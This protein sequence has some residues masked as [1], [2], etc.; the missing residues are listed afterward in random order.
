[1]R[2]ARQTLSKP[3]TPLFGR[4]REI[5]ELAG[6]LD[7]ERLVTLLGPGGCGKTR[8]AIETALRLAEGFHD[9]IGFVDL[10]RVG[11][12]VGPDVIGRLVGSALAFS[13]EAAHDPAAYLGERRLLLV[14]DNCEHV[15]ESAAAC[16][17][18]LLDL[19]PN[20]R[21]LATSREALAV[22]GE[23]T[24]PLVPLACPPEG[25]DAD[26][27]A[28]DAT[29]M[30]LERARRVQ[31]TFTPS[32][33]ELVA[34]AAIARRL[35]GI[36][37]ALELAAARVR[38]LGPQEILQGLDANLDLVAADVR[39]AAPRQH[40]LRASMQWSYDLLSLPE[41][42]VLRRLAVFPG[43]FD[44]AAADAVAGD[45]SAAVAVTDRLLQLVDKSL[46]TRTD[47]GLRLL[48]TV[49]HY[50]LERLRDSGEE[51]QTRER[52]RDL[53]LRRAQQAADRLWTD[54]GI[55]AYQ[56]LSATQDDALQALR[57]CAARGDLDAVA[58]IVAAYAEPLTMLWVG[59]PVD[60][61]ELAVPH[62]AHVPAPARADLLFAYACFV[63]KTQS[64]P[65][66]GLA[67]LAA[68]TVD[69]HLPARQRRRCVIAACALSAYPGREASARAAEVRQEALDAGH[70]YD[71]VVAQVVVWR[72]AMAAARP[73]ADEQAELVG[74]LASRGGPLLMSTVL[75]NYTCY[76]SAPRLQIRAAESVLQMGVDAIPSV[77]R[78]L[79]RDAAF[80]EKTLGNFSVAAQHAS[81]VID[82]F[83][84]NGDRV[85]A[86]FMFDVLALGAEADG[87]LDVALELSDRARE[88]LEPSLLWMTFSPLLLARAAALHVARHEIHRA[89]LLVEEMVAVPPERAGP[90]HQPLAAVA[91]ALI[92][93]AADDADAVRTA[94]EALVTAARAG[95]FTVGTAL[96]VAAA[97]DVISAEDTAALERSARR[98]GAASAVI[99]RHGT[100]ASWPMV[101]KLAA[102]TEARLGALLGDQRRDGLIAEGRGM[103]VHALVELVRP[104]DERRAR[105]S[106]GWESLTDAESRVAELVAEGKAN[107]EIAEE[108]FV[109][110][111]TVTTHLTH[112]YTKTG[113]SS[114]NELT[115]AAVRRR[116]AARTEGTGAR[117]ATR[118]SPATT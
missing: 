6:L 74:E 46:V 118:T 33:T 45:T 85:C 81:A 77:H 117:Q 114:R 91:G 100:Q 116:A 3:R 80:A 101:A 52:H 34:I 31:P 25:A 75:S 38:A 39:T 28:Y 19:A 89:R 2:G 73:D 64:P 54:D 60:W 5:D 109:S 15:V 115:V 26:L 9:G 63:L 53:V 50:A 79:V 23:V 67:E 105:P 82:A 55:A 48:E 96:R 103:S 62:A 49:R 104:G 8:L 59:A 102:E 97:A 11:A 87:D 72:T 24:Y 83:L 86:G 35:D 27:M 112:I 99:D 92:A 44:A 88:H 84:T 76:R 65:P 66:A 13:D 93:L 98:I 37:L 106:Y 61:F 30:F 71:A 14:V 47:V 4:E 7:R 1:M 32:E 94:Q 70:L 57:W 12:E 113:L 20:L 58:G 36:P 111:R 78:H 90:Y 29:A 10:T 41:Q 18:R 51:D 69:D 42:V 40:T 110:V 95:T 43:V 107:R 108:L 22:E 21:V 16:V 68:A 17:D 56:E